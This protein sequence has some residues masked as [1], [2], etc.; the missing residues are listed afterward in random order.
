[1]KTVLSKNAPVYSTKDLVG[2]PQITFKNDI[3]KGGLPGTGG[4]EEGKGVG[5]S[6]AAGRKFVGGCAPLV[7]LIF[8]GDGARCGTFY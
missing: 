6:S 8:V 7:S 2:G 3:A 1:M 4:V 5:A